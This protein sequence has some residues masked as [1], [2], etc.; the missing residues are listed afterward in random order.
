MIMILT[1][2]N[3]F[4]VIT[5]T[6]SEEHCSKDCFEEKFL[7]FSFC[8]NNSSATPRNNHNKVVPSLGRSNASQVEPEQRP[9]CAPEDPSVVGCAPGTDMD[10]LLDMH[11]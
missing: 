10:L 7:N 6:R 2:E 8:S 11:A 5:D 3:Y 1:S 4:M 9:N